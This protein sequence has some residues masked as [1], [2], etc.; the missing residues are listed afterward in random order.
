MALDALTNSAP[1]GHAASL[2]RAEFW[3][4]VTVVAHAPR[5]GRLP[6][7]A[8]ALFYVRVV[9]PGGPGPPSVVHRPT[10]QGA[11]HYM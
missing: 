11:R 2:S 3:I 9:V 10:P 7:L 8:A 5:S 4:P 6:L 1:V